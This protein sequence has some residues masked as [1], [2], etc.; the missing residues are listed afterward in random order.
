MATCILFPVEGGN[1]A[2]TNGTTEAESFGEETTLS[3]VPEGTP[4]LYYSYA[5]TLR[6]LPHI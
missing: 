3:T 4:R 1:D 5:T 6:F 2:V